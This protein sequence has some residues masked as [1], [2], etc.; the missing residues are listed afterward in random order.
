MGFINYFVNQTK[1]RCAKNRLQTPNAGFT[2]D[3]NG[4]IAKLNFKFIVKQVIN[5]LV[6]AVVVLIILLL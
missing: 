2:I 6:I 5:V 4:N 1:R 3:Q